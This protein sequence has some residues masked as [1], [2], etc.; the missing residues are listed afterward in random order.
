MNNQTIR[1]Q[2]EHPED[3]I[4]AFSKELEQ[5]INNMSKLFLQLKKKNMEMHDFW[6]GDQYERFS[7]FVELS[8]TD[9]VKQLKILNSLQSDLERKAML[10]QEARKV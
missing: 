9:A 8:V 4:T 5:Y 1:S 10:M 6:R 2:F 7:K 3:A